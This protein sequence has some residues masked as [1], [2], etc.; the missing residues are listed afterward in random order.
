METPNLIFIG[1]WPPP[2]GGIASHLNQLL[3]EIVKRGYDVQVFSYH[4]KKNEISIIDNGVNITFFSPK[5]YLKKRLLFIIGKLIPFWRNLSR[6]TWKDMVIGATVAVKIESKIM[7]NKTNI[8]F[9]YDN[10]KLFLNPFISKKDI[11]AI[12]ST[13]YADFYLYPLR[14]VPQKYFLKICLSHTTKV[15]SC[16]RYC[17]ES[18]SNFLNSSFPTQVIFNNVDQNKFSPEISGLKVRSAFN[19]E[20]DQILLLTMARVSNA[21]G[22]DFIL[23]IAPKLLNEFPKLV[24][25]IAGAS[26]DLSEEVEKQSLIYDRLKFKFNVRDEEKAEYFSACDIFSAPTK[27]LHACMG[28]ANIE[29]MMTGK[30]VISSKSGGHTE[31]IDDGG[32][33]F[34]IPFKNGYISEEKYV[35]CLAKLYN[36]KDLRLSMGLHARLRA[37]L[38]F[39]NSS[40]VDQHISLIKEV[41]S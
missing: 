14:Y 28:I 11:N 27:D 40:I 19:I 22:I 36:D 37:E 9:T 6:S 33:G 12:F 23:K 26:G 13:I 3:P 29:A 2:F 34:L 10:D 25:L 16:S 5:D 17:A 1:S 41:N 32:S 21:M 24:I 8:I 4:E 39:S 18:A 35:N 7:V 15:L 31:T 20:K 30:P 38:L